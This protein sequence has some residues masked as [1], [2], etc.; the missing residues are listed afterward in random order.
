MTLEPLH[1]ALLAEAHATA[2]RLD[3]EARRG[4]DTI[5]AEAEQRAAASVARHIEEARALAHARGER[6]RAEAHRRA[7]AVVLS[8]R[9]EAFAE[10]ARR[11][12]D[13]AR[14]IA[15]GP[16]FAAH[17]ARL[18]EDARSRLAGAGPGAGGDGAAVEIAPAPGGGIIA[19]AG[20]RWIDCSLTA[21]V[22]R[23][24]AAATPDLDALWA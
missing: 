14:A 23:A 6:E 24:L 7:R 18:T 10:L 5:V 22:D 11:A 3:D 20:T 16:E 19:H 13:A 12:H 9:S 1:A 2:Q 4:A 17:V 8:A 21:E 15:D